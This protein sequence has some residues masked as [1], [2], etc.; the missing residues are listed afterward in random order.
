LGVSAS[1]STGEGQRAGLAGIFAVLSLRRAWSISSAKTIRS[2]LR[3]LR[4]AA[5]ANY[6]LT[7]P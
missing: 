4:P 3:G 7:E 1:L 6:E 2:S 5:H